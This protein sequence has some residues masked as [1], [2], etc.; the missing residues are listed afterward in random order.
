MNYLAEESTPSVISD[1]VFDRDQKKK[2]T[3]NVIKNEDGTTRKRSKYS[4]RK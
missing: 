1:E 4:L 3:S 2:V